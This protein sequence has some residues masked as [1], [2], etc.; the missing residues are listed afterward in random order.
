MADT[1]KGPDHSEE[2]GVLCESGCGYCAYIRQMVADLPP[3]SDA[4]VQRVAALLRA[5]NARK[6]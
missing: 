1:S 4:Q 3:M 5:A 2:L 6:R